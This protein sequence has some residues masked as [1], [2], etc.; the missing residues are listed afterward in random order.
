MMS[1]MHFAL[2]A[3]ALVILAAAPQSAGANGWRHEHHA[4]FGYARV[5]HYEDRCGC[6][7]W[8]FEYHRQLRYTYGADLDPRSFD[9]TEPYYYYGPVKAYPRYWSTRAAWPY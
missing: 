1:K 2:T 8:T 5:Y 6:L 9:A 3:I 4:R 7:W